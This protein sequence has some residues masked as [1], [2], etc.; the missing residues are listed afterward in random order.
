[1]LIV[2][3]A[4]PTL[5]GVPVSIV[6][7]GLA[8]ARTTIRPDGT[9]RVR[10]AIPSLRGGRVLRYQA[11]LGALHSRNVRLKRRTITTSAKLQNG[12][13][14]IKGRVVNAPKRGRRPLV[15]LLARLRSC[16]TTTRTQIGRARLR[17]DGT[18]SV[19]GA[20]LASVGVAVYQVRVQLRRKH[21]TFSLPQTIAG[22]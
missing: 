1:V 4:K 19:S 16:G 22:R 8:V 9:F 11:R 14:V 18:F 12:R 15:R 6:E 13:I 5:A 20:P 7:G 17:R 3:L 21:L 10:V 2:G